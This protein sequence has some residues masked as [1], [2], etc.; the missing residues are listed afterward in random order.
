MYFVRASGTTAGKMAFGPR[1]MYGGLP[2]Q[3]TYRHKDRRHLVSLASRAEGCP[4]AHTKYMWRPEILLAPSAYMAEP[5]AAGPP[6]PSRP[7]PPR[8]RPRARAVS[9]VSRPRFLPPPPPAPPPP[10]PPPPA[11][12]S[13]SSLVPSA[14]AAPPPSKPASVRSRDV[15]RPVRAG[16]RR[17]WAGDSSPRRARPVLTTNGIL[18]ARDGFSPHRRTACAATRA[19]GA[20]SAARSPP[21]RP[22]ARRWWSPPLRR[23]LLTTVFACE[24]LPP[25]RRSSRGPARGQIEQSAR[26]DPG[27]GEPGALRPSWCS[28]SAA[29]GRAGRRPLAAADNGLLAR[30][31]RDARV[32]GAGIAVPRLVARQAERRVIVC[33]KVLRLP[34]AAPLPRRVPAVRVCRPGRPY[35]PTFEVDAFETPDQASRK[36]AEKERLRTREADGHGAAGAAGAGGGRRRRRRRQ[37]RR[38][39]RRH[40]QSH[41]IL[42]RMC[43]QKCDVCVKVFVLKSV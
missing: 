38:Q 43:V 19:S 10:P 33:G 5:P 30:D 35:D 37:Q 39:Q 27:D 21:S 9:P 11:S 18:A 29:G 15:D 34:R 20:A 12:A 2:I 3:N 40:Q 32:R 17:L 4:D 22:P 26:P 28:A 8:P 36:R 23:S 41:L 42:L 14:S 7:P 1:E 31:G 25:A 6:P 13:A 16:P 24:A